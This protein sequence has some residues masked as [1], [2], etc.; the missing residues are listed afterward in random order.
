MAR[1]IA[2]RQPL[3]KPMLQVVVNATSGADWNSVQVFANRDAK[4]QLNVQPQ[5]MLRFVD[6]GE[7]EFQ[8]DMQKP[9]TGLPI[10][11]LANYGCTCWLHAS[12]AHIEEISPSGGVGEKQP[13]DFDRSTN[14]SARTARV[15]QWKFQLGIL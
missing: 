4:R 15:C 9:R 3:A 8:P 10:E 5:L 13:Y 2:L 1:V 14:N 12:D 7:L 11:P 6:F